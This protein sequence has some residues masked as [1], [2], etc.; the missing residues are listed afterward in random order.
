MGRRHIISPRPRRPLGLALNPLGDHPSGGAGV[1]WRA[2]V[3]SRWRDTPYFRI[4]RRGRAGGRE[5]SWAELPN[6]NNAVWRRDDLGSQL[7]RTA[8]QALP[9]SNG[10]GQGPTTC[11][12]PTTAP[13]SSTISEKVASGNRLVRRRVH[14]RSPIIDQHLH[15]SII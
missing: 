12:R 7:A 10:A 2:T 15:W 6:K 5:L 3:L 9:P 4:P 13:A 1:R 8:A 14:S 11:R